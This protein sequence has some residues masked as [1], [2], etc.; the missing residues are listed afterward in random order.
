LAAGSQNRLSSKCTKTTGLFFKSEEV[1]AQ[2]E[3]GCTATHQYSTEDF[4]KPHQYSTENFSETHQYSTEDFS[5]THQ[6]S[7]E[8][9]SKTHQYSKEEFSKKISVQ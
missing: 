9:F 8:D 2:E 1:S 4:S 7:A 3:D 6:C 5:K